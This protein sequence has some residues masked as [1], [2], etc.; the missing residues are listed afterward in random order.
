MSRVTLGIG[1]RCLDNSVWTFD[2]GKPSRY[3]KINFYL[4]VIVDAVAFLVYFR[5]GFKGQF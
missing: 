2:I 5:F 3:V 1:L 4:L